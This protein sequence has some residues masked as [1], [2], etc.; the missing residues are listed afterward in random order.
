MAKIVECVPN[1]S[2]GRDKEKITTIVSSMTAFPGVTLLDQESDTDHNRSVITIVGEPEQVFKAAFEGIKKAMTLIDLRVHKGEHPRMGATDVVPFIPISNTTM[3]ECIELS[4]RLGAKV[5]EEL[6]IPVYLYEQSATR[7]ERVNLADVRKGQFEGIRDEIKTNPDRKPDFGPSEVHPSAGIMAIGARMILIAFNVNLAHPDVTYA[8]EIAKAIRFKDGGFHYTKA[9]GFDIKAR[10]ITQVS[11]NMVNYLGTPLH[12]AFEFVK[13]EAMRYG[14]NVIGTEIVGLTPIRA[15]TQATEH[16]LRIPAISDEQIIWNAP[17]FKM[18]VSFN[19]GTFTS[20]LAQAI[21]SAL[22][23]QTGGF[24]GVSS[25]IEG[26][27]IKVD[28]L[29]AKET[30]L[31]RVFHALISELERF[32]TTITKTTITTMP[33]E[34]VIATADHYLRVENFK[35]DQVFEVRLR[36]KQG[37]PIQQESKNLLVD[38]T[39]KG[40]ISETA[41]DN[42]APGGGSV[43]D[44]W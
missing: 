27:T 10:N 25:R 20:E 40:F 31:Y 43:A 17:D 3:E 42:P 23:E 29:N 36:Q 28:I 41:S 4:K 13:T 9:M 39:V 1:F 11:M 34:I 38:K 12:R 24:K 30:A 33:V 8:K 7:P 32:G 37:D 5:A 35:I 22:S 16:F 18:N 26:Q 6:K 15:L 2:E 21:P 44:L 19:V 14:I